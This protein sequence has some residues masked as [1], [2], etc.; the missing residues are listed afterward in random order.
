MDFAKIVVALK[1]SR[2]HKQVEGFSHD[3]NHFNTAAVA[4]AMRSAGFVTRNNTDDEIMTQYAR[5]IF[6]SDEESER[7]GYSIPQ[8]GSLDAKHFLNLRCSYLPT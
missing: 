7:Q 2:T 5:I 6:D 1:E 8:V 3:A 4:G